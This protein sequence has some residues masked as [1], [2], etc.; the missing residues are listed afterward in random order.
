MTIKQ[1]QKDN[2]LMVNKTD[3]LIQQN[4]SDK[5]QV[6]AQEQDKGNIWTILRKFGKMV[7]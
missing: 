4:I 6:R 1:K 2:G 5:I 7:F 3:H